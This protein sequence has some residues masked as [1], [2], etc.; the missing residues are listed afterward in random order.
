M[1]LLFACVENA[2]RSQ[3]AAAWARRLGG[4]RVRVLSAGSAPAA[5]VHPEVAAVLREEG[6]GEAETPRSVASLPAGAVDVVVTMGCGDACPVVAAKR[7]ED[8][9]VRDPKGLPIGEVRRIAK[10][11]RSRVEALLASLG[12]EEAGRPTAER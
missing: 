11:V 7:R 2:G 6:L 1:T 8:W 10:D 4:D 9:A 5:R 12:I 3:I